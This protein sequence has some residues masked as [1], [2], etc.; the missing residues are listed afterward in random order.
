MRAGI[1]VVVLLLLAGC[2]ATPPQSKGD[3]GPLIP[4][5]PAATV[6]KHPLAKYIEFA[7]FRMREASAGKLNVKFVAINHSEADLGDLVVKVR[8]LTTVAKPE[9]PPISEFDVK[10]P[11]LGP[12]EIREIDASGATKLRIYELPDWQFLRAEFEIVSP[13]A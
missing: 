7:G 5:G 13:A 10:I 3:K 11:S 9:D 4:A 8:L 6:S 2:S 1:A 12:Q